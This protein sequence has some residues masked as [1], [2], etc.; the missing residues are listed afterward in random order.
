MLAAASFPIYIKAF[1]NVVS[2][3]DQAWSVTGAKKD[4]AS[5][6]NFII[7]QVC[8]L[9][10]IL[11]T[12]AVGI[13]RDSINAMV[14]VATIWCGINS[15]VL[16]VFLIVAWD[17]GVQSRRG[18][19][20]KAELVKTAAVT[21]LLAAPEPLQTPDQL[22]RHQRESGDET[23]PARRAVGGIIPDPSDG[24]PETE[25]V[26]LAGRNNS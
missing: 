26:A 7:P 10:F 3:R 2:G 22:I 21:A 12:F 24:T 16:L 25:P 17:E 4:Q 23:I 1:M 8:A 20:D 9:I 19:D 18:V 14:S 13:W 6:F 5:P 11:I 15:V